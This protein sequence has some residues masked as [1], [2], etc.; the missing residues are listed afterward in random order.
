MLKSFGVKEDITY[1]WNPLHSMSKPSLGKWL[2]LITY[3]GDVIMHKSNH[4]WDREPIVHGERTGEKISLD[5]YTKG[6]LV[7]LCEDVNN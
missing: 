2:L 5:D 1:F 4:P 6:C 3:G 7:E